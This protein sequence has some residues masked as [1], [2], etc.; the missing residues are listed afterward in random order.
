MTVGE[1]I[2]QLSNYPPDTIL[3]MSSDEEG[4]SY[5]PLA[6]I[7]DN[8]MYIADST[9]SGEITPRYLTED[10]RKAGWEEEDVYDYVEEGYEPRTDGV[11][12]I[13]LWPVN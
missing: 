12:A 13:V 8:C 10:M 5:S 9:W 3:V 6:A 7:D 4:N 11:P 1:L 2:E